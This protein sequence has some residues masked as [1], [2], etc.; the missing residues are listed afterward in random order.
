MWLITDS[1]LSIGKPNSKSPSRLGAKVMMKI[2]EKTL[3]TYTDNS[4]NTI[5]GRVVGHD[6]HL[7]VI[8]QKCGAGKFDPFAIVSDEMIL[9]IGEL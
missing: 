4:G 1:V 7:R 5:S 8:V 2:L 9:T 6:D 3:I